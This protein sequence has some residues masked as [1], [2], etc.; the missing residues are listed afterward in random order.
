[1][2]K[3][4][5]IQACRFIRQLA[6]S[7]EEKKVL[8]QVTYACPFNCQHCSL[9]GKGRM[10]DLPLEAN[11]RIAEKL[12]ALGFDQIIFFGGEPLLYPDFFALASHVQ[13]LG[14]KMILRMVGAVSEEKLAEISQ[15]GFE[16]ITLGLDSLDNYKQDFFK[17]GQGAL[18]KILYSAN[19]LKKQGQRVVFRITVSWLNYRDLDSMI[20]FLLNKG[21]EVG[22]RRFLSIGNAV[23]ASSYYLLDK[24][25]EKEVVKTLLPWRE[26]IAIDGFD[27][28]EGKFLNQCLAGKNLAAILPDGR[29]APCPLMKDLDPR[30]AKV[31]DKDIPDWSNELASGPW[32]MLQN[33]EKTCRA[34]SY[35]EY[36][37]RG[38]LAA[39][40]SFNEGYDLL[41]GQEPRSRRTTEFTASA[42]VLNP[43]RDK[44]LFIQ[45]V[46]EP[47]VGQWLPPGG[48]LQPGES[49]DR[50]IIRKVREETG[51]DVFY[52]E[53]ALAP[54]ALSDVQ[55]DERVQKVALPHSI[56]REFI[57][58]RHD[59]IDLI[60]VLFAF[61]EG[62]LK[63]QGIQIAMWMD[64][65]AINREPMPT[66]V[67][68]A[69]LEL[70]AKYK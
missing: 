3:E 11:K 33:G 48:H 65:E 42:F 30:L 20:K 34:C 26:L 35:R 12:K 49:P 6:D 17:G 25:E 64:E 32:L 23:H 44:I 46:K 15:L 55:I 43:Q 68:E 14:F 60:Y 27:L 1:M 5:K 2:I 19:Y 47:L 22:V 28:G 66:N 37:G 24:G 69:A 51:L 18:E 4:K 59:H 8:W 41:C 40:I 57:D 62:P 39:A 9:G 31:W 16:H 13:S 56:Q 63:V 67:R 36:C 10:A 58:Y 7:P 38:C 70:L 53:A 52:G 61:S 21:F 50:A 54:V 45:R 29:M